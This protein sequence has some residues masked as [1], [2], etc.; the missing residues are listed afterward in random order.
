MLKSASKY[1][2][3]ERQQIQAIIKEKMVELE[4]YVHCHSFRSRHGS[5]LDF[6]RSMSLWSKPNVN[7]VRKWNNCP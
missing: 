5:S 4:R 3:F 1:R 2:E 7:R 6:E